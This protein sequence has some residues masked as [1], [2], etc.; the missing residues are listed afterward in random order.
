M[1]IIN[2]YTSVPNNNFKP[3]NYIVYVLRYSYQMQ[4][5]VS[6]KKK[7]SNNNKTM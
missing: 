3:L 2:N 7:K 6:N 4:N 5:Y 1:I